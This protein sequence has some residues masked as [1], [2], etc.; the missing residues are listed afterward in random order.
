LIEL[1][2]RTLL[3]RLMRLIPSER[4]R[5]DEA[6]VRA[7]KVLVDNPGMACRIDGH[8]ILPSALVRKEP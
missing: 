7:I 2:Q 3:E 1:R 5:Q 8:L 6:L 4:R